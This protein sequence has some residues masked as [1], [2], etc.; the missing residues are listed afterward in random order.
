MASSKKT[1]D[2]DSLSFQTLYIK[3]QSGLQIS[4]YTIPVIPGDNTVIKQLEYLTPEQVLSVGNIYI[5]PSTIPNI[6]TSINTLSTNQRSLADSVSSLSTT[7][8]YN[9]IDI[10]ST[11]NL[12]FSS[13]N[14]Y[15][16]GPAYSNLANKYT[17]VQSQNIDT[18]NLQGVVLNLGDT[19]SS[20]SSQYSPDFSS[21][22]FTLETTFNQGPAV[23]TMSTY[24]SQYFNGLAESIPAYSTQ[25]YTSISTAVGQ[26]ASSIIAY[27]NNIQT[28]V[29]QVTGPGVSTLSTIY[30]SSL[31]S[32]YKIL[33]TYDTSVSISS[34]STNITNTLSIFSTQFSLNSGI[35]GICSISTYISSQYGYNLANLQLVAGS[36]GLSTMST[37]F[38]SSIIGIG[39]LVNDLR[40]ATTICTFSTLLQIQINNIDNVL[41]TVGYTNTILQQQLV[42]DSLST[43][44]TTF[45]NNYTNVA[46]LSSFSTF[47]PTIYSTLS[48][49]FNVQNPQST[50]NNIST[51]DGSNNS[52]I[53]NFISFT[54]PAIYTGPGISSLSTSIGPNFSS[55][56]TL[57]QS[58]FSSFSNS[59]NN[60]SSVRL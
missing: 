11:T 57:L 46:S 21:L 36:P 51:F 54:Y 17:T 3:A 14:G 39:Q 4:S 16:Y 22:G 60:I 34:L 24:F 26:D 12:Y 20:I 25:V 42:K 49:L 19:F 37:T 55:L 48:T 15:T 13:A 44:S 35:P 53:L 1:L 45:G 31:I 50:V 38:T 59:I 2:V 6:L 9:I 29:T 52:T 8:G 56:S 28:L 7:L 40:S 23:S 5:T 47:L 33:S 18:L 58:T 43:L 30:I 32:Y 10:Q 27:T 41:Y